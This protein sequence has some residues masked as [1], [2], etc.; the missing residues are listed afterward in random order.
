MTHGI[1]IFP[2][3][4]PTQFHL[5]AVNHSP[6]VIDGIPQ[7]A[8]DSRIEHFLVDLSTKSAQ[9]INTINH[10]MIYT[11][12]DVYSLGP[13]EVLVTNDHYN[14]AGLKRLAEDVF[15]FLMV[16]WTD[17]VHI[18]DNTA[19]VVADRLHNANGLGHG[20][21]GEIV[22]VDAAGGTI[23]TFRWANGRL[24]LLTTMELS[25]A[26]D[27]PTYFDD[28]YKTADSDA[29]G[30]LIGG[31]LSGAHLDKQC[32]DINANIPS[33]VH[34]IR[35]GPQGPEVR[36]LFEDDGRFISSA[37]TVIL[38]PIKPKKGDQKREAWA[39]VDGP[40]AR[41]VAVAKVDLTDWAK[42]KKR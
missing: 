10:S 13:N 24:E 42:T 38:V 31:L 33:A 19:T 1:D 23:N 14:K 22:E 30:Y 17:I 37:A 8:A 18:R 2:T 11:P 36:L 21:D 40:W 3:D 27:N 6:K 41:N 28:P 20:P 7:A 5:H 15:T 9:H 16:S 4:K 34:I 29:S 12:N 26:M 32:R 35:Q 25:L 39:V